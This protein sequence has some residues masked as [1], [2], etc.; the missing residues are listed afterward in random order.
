MTVVLSLE[1]KIDCLDCMN[2]YYRIYE[3]LF[4]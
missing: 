3:D 4:E 2:V 1:Y